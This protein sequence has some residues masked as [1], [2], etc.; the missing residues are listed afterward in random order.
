MNQ[1][2]LSFK[3]EKLVVDYICLNIQDVIDTKTIARFL[4]SIG[5]NSSIYI[6]DIFQEKDSLQT[7]SNKNKYKVSFLIQCLNY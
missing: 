4:F 7:F 2:K 5:F 3:S 6:N 1:N